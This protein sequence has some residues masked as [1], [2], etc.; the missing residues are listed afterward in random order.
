MIWGIFLGTAAMGFSLLLV[1]LIN[2]ARVMMKRTI[3]GDVVAE[4]ERL[5]KGRPTLVFAVNREHARKLAWRFAARGHKV[6]YLDWETG[7]AERKRQQ[8]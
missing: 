2:I 6:A 1:T 7:T 5:A 4:W 8:D 3:L